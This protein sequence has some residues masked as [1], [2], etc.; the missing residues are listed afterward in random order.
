MVP[1][2]LAFLSY[3]T[4]WADPAERVYALPLAPLLSL[5]VS[6]TSGVEPATGGWLVGG[7][8]W[9]ALARGATPKP[10]NTLS[11]PLALAITAAWAAALAALSLALAR[12]VKGVPLEELVSS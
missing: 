12:R 2:T 8:L 4:L 7:W 9:E 10:P 1:L 5:I 11:A 6:A 3:A